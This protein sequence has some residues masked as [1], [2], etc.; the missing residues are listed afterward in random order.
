MK[1][2]IVEGTTGEYSDR[3]EWIVCA[4][5]NEQKAKAHV[6]G[7]AKRAREIFLAGYPRQRN[8]FDPEMQM[9]YS[10]T[11]YFLSETELQE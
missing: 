2:Y 10:G 9:D 8:E 3:M 6:E 11:E 7:A 5:T 4:F 1:I